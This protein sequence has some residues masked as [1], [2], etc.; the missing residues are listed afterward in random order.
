MLRTQALFVVVLA[1]AV[2]FAGAIRPAFARAQPD[3]QHWVV[4]PIGNEARY[5]VREMLFNHDFPN[6]AIGTAKDITGDLYVDPS[7]SIGPASKIVI[8]VATMKSDQGRRDKIIRT[9]SITTDKYPTVTIVPKS[10]IGLVAKP[11]AATV[12]FGLVG[13]LTI[14]GTTRPTTWKV[15]AHSQGPDV[16]GSASTAITFADFSLDKPKAQMALNVEDTIKLEYDFH[17]TR[18]TP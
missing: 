3:L 9:Q 6:D 17:F 10:L 7:G 13:D 16:V 12:E 11:S 18:K 1:G 15:T 5:R 14:H 2:A 4:A 8:S